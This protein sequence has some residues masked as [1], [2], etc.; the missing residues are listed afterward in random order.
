MANMNKTA[1]DA[2]PTPTPDKP[3]TP[4]NMAYVEGG[5][6]MMGRNT[7]DGGEE[8]E[9]PA[10]Q[11]RV[12]PFYIDLNEVTREDYQ[13]FVQVTNRRPPLDWSGSDYPA[14]TGRQPVTGVMWSDANAY[15]DWRS[16]RDGGK[17]RLPT[18][19]EWEFAARGKKGLLYPWGQAWNDSLA[20]ANGINN[21]L[22]DVGKY[23]GTSPYGAF[24][25]AGNAWEWTSSTLEPYRGGKVSKRYPEKLMVIRGGAY[26]SDKR[27]ATT[28]YRGGL[29]A[30]STDNS[31]TGFR[32]VKNFEP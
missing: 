5:D 13:K 14:G 8:Y 26:D 31:K 10:H 19:E 6:F 29:Q 30:E 17:Y 7:D 1:E 15:A 2:K 4:P 28:S 27:N 18:E 24:D 20:N 16:R 25:M 9:N 21:G 11:V 12:E 32:C 22:A 23:K 3:T